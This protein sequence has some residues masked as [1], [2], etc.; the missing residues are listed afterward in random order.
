MKQVIAYVK[1]HKLPEV[2]EALRE[3]EGLTGMSHGA[4]QGFG[5]GPAID[6]VK[7]DR[8]EVFCKDGLAGKVI[9]TILDAAHEGLRGDG[10][11]YVCP[12]EEAVRISTKENGETAV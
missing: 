3:I 5:R 4:V 6:L 8:V 7:M 10:K 2:A 1:S 9:N 12:V 11:V